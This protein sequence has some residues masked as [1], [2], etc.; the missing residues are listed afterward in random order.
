MAKAREL[1]AITEEDTQ[2]VRYQAPFTLAR[3]FGALGEAPGLGGVKLDLLPESLLEPGQ[4]YYL[5]THL[6]LGK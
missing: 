5:S 1:A 6:F 4:L 2:V 3:L